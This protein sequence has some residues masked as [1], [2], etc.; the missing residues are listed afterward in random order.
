MPVDG[1][2]GLENVR[3]IDKKKNKINGYGKHDITDKHY[4]TIYV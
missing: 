4:K 3:V 2:D 1:D